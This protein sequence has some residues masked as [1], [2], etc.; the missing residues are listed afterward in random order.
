MTAYWDIA[1]SFLTM[2]IPLTFLKEH[3]FMSAGQTAT[4]LQR[5]RQETLCYLAD[6]I[7][8]QDHNYEMLTHFKSHG[9]M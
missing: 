7:W 5:N 6:N 2:I 1:V 8:E 3:V 9:L 4:V